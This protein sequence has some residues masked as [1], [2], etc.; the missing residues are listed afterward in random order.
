MIL[1]PAGKGRTP[2]PAVT[3]RKATKHQRCIAF[4]SA[5]SLKALK[6]IDYVAVDFEDH[7]LTFF[8]SKSDTFKGTAAHRLTSD[9][10]GNTIGRALYLPARMLTEDMV[11]SDRYK[12]T[13][14]RSKFT[15]TF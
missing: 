4:N 1:I 10:G 9:G 3:V 7:K 11:P 14:T 2:D 6:D 8:P 12:A 5:L 13:V 15:I